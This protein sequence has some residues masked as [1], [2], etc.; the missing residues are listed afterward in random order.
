[1]V[2]LH[3]VGSSLVQLEPGQPVQILRNSFSLQPHHCPRRILLL[4]RRNLRQYSIDSRLLRQRGDQDTVLECQLGIHFHCIEWSICRREIKVCK[5]FLDFDSCLFPLA[6]GRLCF[7]HG[8]VI[9]HIILCCS[10]CMAPPVPNLALLVSFVEFT[11]LPR[12]S[13][14]EL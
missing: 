9:Y 6:Q 7:C 5:V 12:V 2:L 4:R 14:C 10:P 11:R 1:M 8:Q 3:S 13:A